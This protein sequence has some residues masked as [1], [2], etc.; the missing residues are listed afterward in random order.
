[1]YITLFKMH[2]NLF[3]SLGVSCRREN[4]SVLLK[5][6]ISDH[7]HLCVSCR[8]VQTTILRNDQILKS[9]I[10]VNC[11]R[12]RIAAETFWTVFSEMTNFNGG[13][14][15]TL[16]KT[17]IDLF[18]SLGVSCRRKNQSVLFKTHISDYLHLCVSCRRVQNTI[19]RNDLIWKK[20]NRFKVLLIVSCQAFHGFMQGLTLVLLLWATFISRHF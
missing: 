6:H 17:H 7:L 8:R 11:Q 19:L 20:G 16:F 1:M 5:T 10:S 14:I 12:L 9:A 15:Y 4:W 18:S 13:T 2:I 3:S